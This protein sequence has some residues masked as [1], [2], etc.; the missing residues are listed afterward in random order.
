MGRNAQ[1]H[2]I[3]G[4]NLIDPPHREI[5][6]HVNKITDG[7]EIRVVVVWKNVEIAGPMPVI[8]MWCAQ[9]IKERKPRTST[10]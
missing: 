3:G 9:T 1:A 6:R 5:N 8:Y 7:I 10:P 2:I 4:V